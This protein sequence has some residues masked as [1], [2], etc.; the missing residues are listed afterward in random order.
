[1]TFVGPF[2]SFYSLKVTKRFGR[3][4]GYGTAVFGWAENGD[5]NIKQDVYQIRRHSKEKATT[6]VYL[7]GSQGVC[8]VKYTIS[9]NP[10][11][12]LQEDNREKFA[13]AV[14]ISETLTDNEKI[15]IKQTFKHTNLPIY[16][17]FLKLFMRDMFALEYGTKS[18]G[19]TEYGF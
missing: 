5:E 19:Q 10:K 8:R 4:Y 6:P 17:K 9:A 12:P 3:P 14:L 1:M 16:H 2:E 11:T 13:L 15:E 18:L 7:R